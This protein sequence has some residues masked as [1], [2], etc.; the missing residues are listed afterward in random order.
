MKQIQKSLLLALITVVCISLLSGCLAIN[1]TQTNNTNLETPASIFEG[2]CGIAASAEIGNNII[3]FPELKITLKN[4]TDKD[5]AA[6]KFY[7]VPQ[8]VYGEEIKSILFQNTLFTDT[9]IPAGETT[10]L[11]YQLV[12]QSVKTV[13]LYVYSVYFADGSEWGNR[14]A[15]SS[16]ILKEAPTIAVTVIS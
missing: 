10:T 8:N 5:I 15:D 16:I 11:S 1:N 4:T 3:N 13:K 12:E 6:I 7:A 2:N 14:N 9:A